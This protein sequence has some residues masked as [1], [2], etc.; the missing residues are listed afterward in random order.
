MKTKF[1]I[2]RAITFYEKNGE[3]YVGERI[4]LKDE[5]SL[6]E[7]SIIFDPSEDD[8]LMYKQYPI[9]KKTSLVFESKIDYNFDFSR[10]EYFYE[11]FSLSD[12]SEL[13]DGVRLKNE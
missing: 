12:E 5:F 11:T 4:L 3:A 2:Q 1:K 9:D 13:K 6:E 7:L 8:P 10:Y